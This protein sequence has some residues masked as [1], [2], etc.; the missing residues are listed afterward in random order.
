MKLH[1]AIASSYVRKVRAVAIELG[2]DGR[3]ELL[4]RSMTPV[5]P[6]AALN[7][8]NPL[9]K[10]PCLVTDAGEALYDSRVISAFLDDLAGGGRMI[11]AE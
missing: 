5:A 6:E 8:D 3:I 4:A 1:F 9:G 11:P 10:I 2:L 7:A